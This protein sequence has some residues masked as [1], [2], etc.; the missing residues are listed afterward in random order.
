MATPALA[1]EAYEVDTH[2]ADVEE[3]PFRPSIVRARPAP[4]D[5]TMQVLIADPE[6]HVAWHR[7]MADTAGLFTACDDPLEID[8]DLVLD[9]RVEKYEGQLCTKG[10]FSKSERGRADDANAAARR[11][12]G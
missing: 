2:I 3:P 11:R 5:I 6:G 9:Q 1:R 8:Y 7:K 10:C 4:E 12:N